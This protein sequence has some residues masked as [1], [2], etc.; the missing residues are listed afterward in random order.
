MGVGY[1]LDLV[2]CVALGIDMYVRNLCLIMSVYTPTC[3]CKRVSYLMT[4]HDATFINWFD[5]SCRRFDCVYPT[6]TARFGVALTSEGLLRVKASSDCSMDC[7]P[8]ED[9]KET[10]C[11]NYKDRLYLV[12]GSGMEINPLW[13]H[14]VI[15]F[16]ILSIYML[17][18]IDMSNYEHTVGC[19]CTT[20]DNYSRAMLHIMFREGNPLACQLL[21]IHNVSYMMR[22]MRTMRE[23]KWKFNK[24]CAYFHWRD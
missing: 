1:P 9:G 23:V 20:C 3:I 16:N 21:T 15:L 19:I 17:N 11:M 24:N 2:V 5:I 6:R 18:N 8:I 13:I 4:W 14:I 7:R 22:L 10:N 12:S